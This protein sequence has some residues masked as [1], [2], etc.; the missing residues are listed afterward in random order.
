[1][2]NLPGYKFTE[3]IHEDNQLKFYRGHTVRDQLPVMIK[4]LL[5]GASPVDVSKIMN[6]YEITRSLDIKGIIK[7]VRLERAGLTIALIME[8]SGAIP[9]RKCQQTSRP[10]LL[11]FFSTSHITTPA[12]TRRVKVCTIRCV[13]Y[14]VG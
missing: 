13:A 9:L 4:A 3:K 1:M 2:L 7:P 12:R 10:D 14:E 11:A 5:A 6:E 8:D